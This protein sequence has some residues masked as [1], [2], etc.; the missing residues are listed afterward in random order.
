MGGGDGWRIAV[1]DRALS[2]GPY[3]G[4]Y[5]EALTRPRSVW[6]VG[7]ACC[8]GL[9]SP[10]HLVVSA[11]RELDQVFWER[12]VAL[13]CR[14]KLCHLLLGLLSPASRDWPVTRIRPPV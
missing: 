11:D 7:L 12:S 9:R 8:H 10:A 2:H 4:A 6:L 14:V 13:W 1:S 3:L 5:L